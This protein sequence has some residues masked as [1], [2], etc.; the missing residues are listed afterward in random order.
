MRV[1]FWAIPKEIMAIPGLSIEARMVYGILFTMVNGENSA[2]PGQKKLASIIG[3]SERSI[4]RYV[5]D[6]ERVGLITVKRKL[7]LKRT[8]R[9][10][11]TGQFVLSRADSGVLSGPDSRVPSYSKRTGVKEQRKGKNASRL[12]HTL[13]RKEQE[14]LGFVLD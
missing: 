13:S 4:R 7:G 5:E 11:L 3:C 2:W 1:E 10:S 12:N 14:E 9:Y 8:N 6:L